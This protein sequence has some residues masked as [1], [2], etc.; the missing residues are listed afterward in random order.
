MRSLPLPLALT[1]RLSP[2][3]VLA[4]AGWALSSGPFA[5]TPAAE[6]QATQKSGEES[7]T[8]PA[9]AADIRAAADSL[10]GTAVDPEALWAL[11]AELPYDVEVRWNASRADGSFDQDGRDA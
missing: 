4:A 6:D 2:V 10:T 11:S 3:V 8:A 9:T 7:P 1:A 5:A